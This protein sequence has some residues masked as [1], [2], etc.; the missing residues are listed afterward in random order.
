MKLFKIPLLILFYFLQIGCSNKYHSF[1]S[2]YHY[3]SIDGT[4]DYSNL[5]TWA[6]HPYKHDPSDSVSLSLREAYHPDTTVDIFFIH[7]TTYTEKEK[8]FGWNAPIDDAELNA[9]TD[10]SSI[11]YQS[12][13]FNEAGRV[14]SPRYRQAH[15]SS[16][17]P[18]NA[19]DSIKAMAA[20]ELAYQDVKTAFEYYLENNHKGRP[21]IIASHSQGS[22]HAKRL[23]SEFFDNKPLQEK[24]IVAYLIGMPLE[25]DRFRTIVPCITPFQTGCACSWRTY[26]EGYKPSFVLQEKFVSVVTN[27]LTW[28]A[29][30]PVADRSMNKGSVLLNFN[31]MVK[32]VT[33]ANTTKSVLWTDKPRF[34]G[35]IFL[36]TKNYH[37]ADMNFYYLSIRENAKQRILSFKKN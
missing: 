7:P 26:K 12:S 37:I 23:L 21:I 33:N 22:Q 32:E 8:Q 4:P 35:N 3:K 11:L 17:Y 1:V 31:K 14:F 28:D 16:Y 27:P 15:L 10:Y 20:F 30:K 36:T 24:L 29:N 18:K 25:P 5:N 19:D 9:K 13:I 34:F 6:A 2:N